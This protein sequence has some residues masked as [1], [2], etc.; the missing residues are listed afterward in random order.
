MLARILSDAEQKR[1]D[2]WE[3]MVAG[4]S[5]EVRAFVKV[6]MTWTESLS[7]FTDH[8]GMLGYAVSNNLLEWGHDVVRGDIYMTVGWIVRAGVN[9]AMCND[10]SI[11]GK[12]NRY[13]YRKKAMEKLMRRVKKRKIHFLPRDLMEAVLSSDT[14]KKET[15]AQWI[16]I[17]EGV[18][19]WVLHPD[20]TTCAE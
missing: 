11:Q 19:E 1:K 5:P 14:N 20:N 2:R 3:K 18:C 4:G 8:D 15:R 10:P 12:E 17:R 16:K 7:W 13:L 9:E 6:A